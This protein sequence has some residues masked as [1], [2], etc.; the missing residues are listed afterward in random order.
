MA[1]AKPGLTA[2]LK[3]KYKRLEKTSHDEEHEDAARDRL[4]ENHQ[5]TFPVS[6]RDGDNHHYASPA[7]P[8]AMMIIMTT[9]RL[10]VKPGLTAHLTCK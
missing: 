7:S 4:A 5:Y 3:C 10:R 6:S 2:H 8:A 1:S 9:H